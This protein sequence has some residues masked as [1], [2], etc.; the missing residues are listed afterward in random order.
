[1]TDGTTTQRRLGLDS[2]YVNLITIG[3]EAHLTKQT[4]ASEDLSHACIQTLY[5]LAYDMI[6]EEVKQ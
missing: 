2:S 6:L 4:R 1:M 3:L 5:L